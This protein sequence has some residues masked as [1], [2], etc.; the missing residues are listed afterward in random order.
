M[1]ICWDGTVVPCCFDFFKTYIL[2]NVNQK[3]L[4]EI[5]N[6]KPMIQLRHSMLNN[7]YMSFNKLCKDCVILHIDPVLGI[8]SGIKT[9]IKDTIT[10]LIGI[11]TEKYLIKVAK[12]LSPSYSLWIDK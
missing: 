2:G 6:D 12:K 4:K 11:K 5:W 3:T 1:S 9:T 8:P 7:T 10:N